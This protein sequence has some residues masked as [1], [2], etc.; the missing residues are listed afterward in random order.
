MDN[1]TA[2][3]IRAL[4]ELLVLASTLVGIT[5]WLNSR[6]DRLRREIQ[7]N[8]L[9]TAKTDERFH[10]KIDA[11]SLRMEAQREFMEHK[12]DR[13]AADIER[14]ETHCKGERQLLRQVINW[15]DA[16]TEFSRRSGD[17]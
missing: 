1:S 7:G 10:G 3:I 15:L 2:A 11:L 5:N 16:H 12:C 6:F 13:L 4:V 8:L 9:D 17:N 14:V